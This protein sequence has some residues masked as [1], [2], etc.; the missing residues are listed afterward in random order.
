M[1][2]TGA[3]LI[4]AQE[5]PIATMNVMSP[6]MEF[7]ARAIVQLKPA[8]RLIWQLARREAGQ[9]FKEPENL[10]AGCSPHD[11]K[12]FELN[13]LQILINAGVVTATKEESP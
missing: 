2:R 13:Y 3:E 7:N 8:L 4:V 5:H 10:L 6:G 9:R 12:Y 11:E 1:P